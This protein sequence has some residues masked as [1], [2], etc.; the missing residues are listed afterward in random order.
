MIYNFCSTTYNTTVF[1]ICETHEIILFFNYY[2]Y[3]GGS[4]KILNKFDPS[5]D[6]TPTGKNIYSYIEIVDI[7][8]GD[9]SLRVVYA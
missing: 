5:R 2:F 7:V 3:L 1:D 6:S 4:S 9:P 8:L